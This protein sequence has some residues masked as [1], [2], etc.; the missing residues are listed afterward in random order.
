M[1]V[2]TSVLLSKL[3]AAGYTVFSGVPCSIFGDLFDQVAED[4]AFLKV[5]AANEGSAVAL[6]AGAVLS[7]HRAVVAFQNSGLG[8]IINPLTSLLMVNEIPVLLFLSVRGHPDEPADEPQH[9]IMGAKT[10]GLLEQLSIE[11]CDFDGT[12]SGLDCTLARCNDAFHRAAPFALLFRKGQLSNCNMAERQ[13]GTIDYG[14]SAGQV[15]DLICQHVDADTLIVSTTGFISRELFRLRDRPLNFYMQGSLGHCSAVAAGLALASPTRLVLALDGDGSVLMHMGI[16]STI[17]YASPKNLIHVV[18]DNESY[19]ST[20]GQLSTSRTSSLD[21]VAS[22]C[23]YRTAT[24][25]DEAEQ[26][27]TVMQQC[28]RGSGPHFVVCK[29]NRVHLPQLP[30]VTSRYSPRQN[31]TMFQRALGIGGNEPAARA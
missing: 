7:G 8:N 2:P 22:A 28:A 12:E 31:K 26:I 4:P 1:P 21:V 25:C 3:R 9:T 17:G 19:V 20:G 13:A 29:V 14:L 16:L 11:W 5:P 15:I 27:I 10:Q 30:R 24:R 18:L 6:A 23:G